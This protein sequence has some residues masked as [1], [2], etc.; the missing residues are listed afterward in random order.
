MFKKILFPIDY[1]LHS[2]TILECIP[3]LRRAGMEEIILVHVIDPAEA[4]LWANVK[5]TI[6]DRKKC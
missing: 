6:T 3:Y 1:S 4:F 5:E 2:N